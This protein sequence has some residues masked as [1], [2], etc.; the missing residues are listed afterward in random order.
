MDGA[1]DNDDSV[2]LILEGF[3]LVLIGFAVG[4]S[5]RVGVIEGIG[6][7]GLVGKVVIDGVK[8]GAE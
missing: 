5:A 4:F 7:I 3:R 6:V 1:R 8:V 2:K